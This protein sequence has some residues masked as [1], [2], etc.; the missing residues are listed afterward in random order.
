MK[1]AAIEYDDGKRTIF[2]KTEK[3]KPF[4]LTEICINIT[5]HKPWSSGLEGI[6]LPTPR[7]CHH[8]KPDK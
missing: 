3:M 1:Q 7:E 4:I 2:C 6:P 5:E 8:Q